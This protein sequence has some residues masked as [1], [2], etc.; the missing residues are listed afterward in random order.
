MS[1]SVTGSETFPKGDN[2]MGNRFMGIAQFG[3]NSLTDVM[4][5]TTA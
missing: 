3:S 2:P 1:W 5:R 4:L